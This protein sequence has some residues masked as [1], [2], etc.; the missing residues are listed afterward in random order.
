MREE[1]DLAEVLRI[2]VQPVVR[3]L[4]RPGELDS[5]SL[6]WAT[7]RIPDWQRPELDGD[8]VVVESRLLTGD[9]AASL[10]WAEVVRLVLRLQAQG[11]VMTYEI[12]D[13][14]D[15]ADIDLEWQADELYGRLQDF[16][17]ESRFGWGQLREG[18]RN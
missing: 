3:V 4:L 10:P 9:E 2:V 7:V 14:V 6:D 18:T 5:I 15:T 1:L 12:A 16:I 13:A 17:V 8:E 11:E